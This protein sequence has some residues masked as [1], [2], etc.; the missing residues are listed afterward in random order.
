MPTLELKRATRLVGQCAKQA[1]A[2]PGAR[3]PEAQSEILVG[4]GT[5]SDSLAWASRLRSLDFE[6]A[7][8]RNS[9]RA[10][11]HLEALRFTYAWTAANALFS[12]DEV[13]RL[14]ATGIPKGELARF[15]LLYTAAALAPV[16]LARYLPRIHSTLELHRTPDDFPWTN[17]RPIRLIDIIYYKYTASTYRTHGATAKKID[18]IVRSRSSVTA[19]DL[20]ECIY[21]SRNWLVHGALLDRSFRGSPSQFVLYCRTLSMALALVLGRAAGKIQGAL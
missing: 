19:L 17:H 18:T 3:T 16:E 11:S 10:E 13:L 14:L 8:K 20:P 15:R 2:T 1:V 7:V 6:T 5:C 9:A 21:A 12:R 4:L